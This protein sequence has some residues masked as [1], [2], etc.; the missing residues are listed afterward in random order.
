M[1]KKKVNR[2]SNERGS[3]RKEIRE[4]EKLSS[5]RVLRLRSVKSERMRGPLWLAP[6]REVHLYFW[7]LFSN[8]L[9]LLPQHIMNS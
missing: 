5:A 4:K 2:F 9:F 1:V 3:Q 6:P 7:R 8:A